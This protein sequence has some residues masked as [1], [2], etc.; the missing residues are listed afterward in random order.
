M[1]HNQKSVLQQQQKKYNP[2]HWDNLSKVISGGRVINYCSHIRNFSEIQKKSNSKMAPIS[3]SVW[4]KNP[5]LFSSMLC[6]DSNPSSLTGPP[7]EEAKE[8]APIRP[9]YV[10]SGPL[11]FSGFQTDVGWLLSSRG[12]LGEEK[13]KFTMFGCGYGLFPCQ[14]G[15]WVWRT[16]DAL[17]WSARTLNGI[18]LGQD[19]YQKTKFLIISTE[20]FVMWYWLLDNV[21]ISKS[22]GKII[23]RCNI[24][25]SILERNITLLNTGLCW[26]HILCAY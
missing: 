2:Q 1:H 13:G 21:T 17:M 20:K 8:P 12:F 18:L 15:F 5:A 7:S 14:S 24:Y 10:T 26:H 11:P 6:R 4:V 25:G 22:H 19:L 9:I 23:L 16:E 3:L